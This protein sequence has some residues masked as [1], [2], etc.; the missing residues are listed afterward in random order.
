[1][2]AKNEAFGYSLDFVTGPP[3]PQE[4]AA[5]ADHRIANSLML[6]ASL[7]RL[8]AK[9]LGK[10]P[11]LTGPELKGLLDDAATR[12]DAV[13]QLHRLIAA[14][15]NADAV[16]SA[17]YLRRV[18]DAA[19]SVG[20]G[21][22]VRLRYNLADNLRLD[23][24]RLASLG[25]LVSEAIINALKHAHPSGVAGEIAI[26]FRKI[27]DEYVLAIEDDGVGLPEGFDPVQDG[28]LGFRTMRHLALGLRG[29]LLHRS[30]PLGLRTELLFPV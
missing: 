12:V 16:D 26:T 29:R 4:T 14:A 27:A 7:L 21:A 28:G 20:T 24:I 19:G 18:G 25:M 30:T 6:V 17:T 1:M 10:Q 8:Q 23:S 11:F 5:E 9:E 2:L 13:S 22:K 3:P 15:P